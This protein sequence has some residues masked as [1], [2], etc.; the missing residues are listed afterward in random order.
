MIIVIFESE[1]ADLTTISFKLDT[2]DYKTLVDRED[3]EVAREL[4]C[5]D[6]NDWGCA[7]EFAEFFIM[8]LEENG[9]SMG[10][11]TPQEARELYLVLLTLL[12]NEL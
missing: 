2:R 1:D 4:C 10:I 8:L 12:E 5:K 11:Y 7:E 9:I 6:R 3:L